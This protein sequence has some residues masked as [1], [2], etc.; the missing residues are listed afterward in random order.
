[1]TFS[2]FA[3]A[4]YPFCNEGTTRGEFVWHLVDMIMDGQPGRAH[5]DGGYQNP[6][7]AMDERTLLN[8]FNG[9]H[10]FSTKDAST[11]YSSIKTEKFENYIERRC[12]GEALIKLLDALLEVED[13]EEKGTV[14][15]VCA[16]LFEKILRELTIKSK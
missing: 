13:I 6:L 2:Q 12:S 7:R 14:P 5:G 8:Y 4:L 10:D 15:E 9:V 16:Q 3:Q 11:I 1:M